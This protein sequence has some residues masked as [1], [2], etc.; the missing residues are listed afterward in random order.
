M[1]LFRAANIADVRFKV[2]RY[3]EPMLLSAVLPVLHSLG[4][5]SPT[6]TRT[7]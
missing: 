2:F 3:G 6:S 5:R 1:H 4:V 7:R